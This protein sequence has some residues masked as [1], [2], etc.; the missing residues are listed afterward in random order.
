[1]LSVLSDSKADLCLDGKYIREVLPSVLE[2]EDAQGRSIPKQALL[3]YFM[4]H[5]EAWYDLE[6]RTALLLALQPILD[7]KRSS[8][9]LPLMLEAA[10]PVSRQFSASTGSADTYYKVLWQGYRCR[11]MSTEALQALLQILNSE[12]KENTALALRSATRAALKNRLLSLM[13]PDQRIQ[14]CENALVLAKH[15]SMVSGLLRARKM[16]T[17]GCSMFQ[18]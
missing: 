1:M 18:G 7:A 12:R 8:L 3:S 17:D 6:I 15:L 10:Q 5:V 14:L 11:H 9:L 2:S 4:S 13:T 16:I